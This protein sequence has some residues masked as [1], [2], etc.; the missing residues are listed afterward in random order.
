[1]NIIRQLRWQADVTQHE[2]AR[3]AGTSQS[4]IASYEA[5]NKSPTVRTVQRLANALGLELEGRFITKMSRED[6]RSLVYHRA[7]AEK[8]RTR[9]DEIVKRARKNLKG[10]TKQHPKARHLF[11][12]WAR[13]L[14]LPPSALIANLLDASEVARDM[15]QVSPFAGALTAPERAQL[16]RQFRSESAA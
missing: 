3:I 11:S 14:A 15:R 13:W 12:R 9:P 8:L 10:L 16:I 6:R 7:I 2:L 4:T 1:M 5:G